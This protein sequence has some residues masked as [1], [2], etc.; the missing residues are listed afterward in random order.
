MWR[1]LFYFLFC[2]SLFF[3]L[4]VFFSIF[5]YSPHSTFYTVIFIADIYFVCRLLIFHPDCSPALLRFHF[6]TFYMLHFLSFSSGLSPA[7]S[8]D[9]AIADMI[10]D[11]TGD[12]FSALVK[13]HFEKDED[14]KVHVINMQLLASIHPSIHQ[15]LC[16]SI[17]VSI[18]P[19]CS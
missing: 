18:Y 8:F 4:F 5:Y 19:L 12:V 16:L 11:G 7:D 14:R 2:V 15:I 10:T 6:F 13:I 1:Y 17:S 3:C 9:E